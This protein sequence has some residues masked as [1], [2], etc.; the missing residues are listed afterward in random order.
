[1]NQRHEPKAQIAI[2]A[3]MT[4]LQAAMF[5]LPSSRG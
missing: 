3:T 2:L 1:M 4:I 5:T